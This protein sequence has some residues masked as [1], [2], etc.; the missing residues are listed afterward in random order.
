[1][2]NDKNLRVWKCPICGT[3]KNRK[4]EL[5][6]ADPSNPSTEMR[7]LLHIIAAHSEVDNLDEIKKKL[8]IV[9]LEKRG[10]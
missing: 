4:G 9:E 10:K 1:M 2:I 8:K 3:V 6:I 5:F 7:I